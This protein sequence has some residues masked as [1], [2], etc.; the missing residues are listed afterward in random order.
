MADDSEQIGQNE[1]E[2]LLNQAKGSA[3]APPGKPGGMP[4]DDIESLLN[5][6]GGGKP[7]TG[8]KAATSTAATRPSIAGGTAT[9][10]RPSGHAGT[11]SNAAGDDIQLLLDQAE[12]AIASVD[13]PSP[14]HADAQAFQFRDLMG[15]APSN[16][17]ATIDLLRDVVTSALAVAVP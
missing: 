6:V 10:K 4:Q 1:I 2:D 3:S 16:E 15:S 14:T 17:K 7:G 12:Q 11:K 5:G 13:D 8:S 9:A